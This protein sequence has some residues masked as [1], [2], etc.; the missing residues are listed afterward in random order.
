MI[1]KTYTATSTSMDQIIHLCC[2][3][4]KQRSKFIFLTYHFIDRLEMEPIFFCGTEKPDA[5]I[6]NY[7]SNSNDIYGEH[8][9]MIWLV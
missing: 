8:W 2:K 5:Y 7:V 6:G 1:M 4:R 3:W 9:G